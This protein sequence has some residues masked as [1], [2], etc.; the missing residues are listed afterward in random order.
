[1]NIRDQVR[2]FRELGPL[3]PE[4]DDSDTADETLEV[5]E[6]ALLAIESPLSDDEAKLLIGAFGH[7]NCFGMAW[8]LLH[9]IETAPTPLPLTEP[10]EDANPWVLRLWRRR[11]N[12]LADS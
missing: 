10:T 7:D 12:A 2:R 4:D 1:M 3:P 9:L 6:H 11:R 8:T 5:L